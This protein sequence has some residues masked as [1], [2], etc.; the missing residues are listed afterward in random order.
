MAKD[1]CTERCSVEVS[2]PKK[3]V[4][5]WKQVMPIAIRKVIL[6]ARPASRRSPN[7]CFSII[8]SACLTRL[9]SRTIVSSIRRS[10]LSEGVPVQ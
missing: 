8:S 9:S 7:S 4:Y 6:K 5:I 1:R 10:Y 2:T 3:A